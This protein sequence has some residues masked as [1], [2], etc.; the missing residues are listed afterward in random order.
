MPGLRRIAR[1]AVSMAYKGDFFL[2][3]KKNGNPRIL[4]EPKF[5]TALKQTERENIIGAYKLIIESPS[6]NPDIE[7]KPLGPHALNKYETGL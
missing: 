2:I 6:W 7:L 3:L 4:T 5:R 1:E